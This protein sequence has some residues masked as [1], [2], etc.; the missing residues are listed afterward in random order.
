M[1]FKRASLFGWA[2]A[3]RIVPAIFA[4]VLLVPGSPVSTDA[5]RQPQIAAPANVRFT[6]TPLALDNLPASAFGDW[7]RAE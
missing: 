5:A 3:G 6:I 1:G 2:G 4:V 7:E